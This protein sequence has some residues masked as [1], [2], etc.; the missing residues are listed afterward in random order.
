MG[1]FSI[2]D[3]FFISKYQLYLG[4]D[5]VLRSSIKLNPSVPAVFKLLRVTHAAHPTT[6][7]HTVSIYILLLLLHT[8]GFRVTKYRGTFPSLRYFLI[9]F[10]IGAATISFFILIFLKLNKDLTFEL[11]IHILPPIHSRLIYALPDFA[12]YVNFY[13]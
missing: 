3:I 10:Q 7:V 11:H 13:P 2:V 1:F 12:S 9:S 5:D 4:G 6:R 8:A